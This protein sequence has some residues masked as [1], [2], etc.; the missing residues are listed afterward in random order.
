MSQ[1]TAFLVATG[2]TVLGTLLRQT[3]IPASLSNIILPAISLPTTRLMLNLRSSQMGAPSPNVMA[4]R[5]LHGNYPP[6]Q[7]RRAGF[8]MGMSGVYQGRGG[9]R[10][11]EEGRTTFVEVEMDITQSEHVHQPHT[12]VAL[13]STMGKWD[14][15]A[16]SAP[17]FASQVGLGIEETRWMDMESAPSLRT[18]DHISSLGDTRPHELRTYEQPINAPNAGTCNPSGVTP[19]VSRP[20]SDATHVSGV[21]TVVGSG[22]SEVGQEMFFLRQ[23]ARKIELIDGKSQ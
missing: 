13:W 4:Q 10:I 19:A 20:M 11:K 12:R 14:D 9:F 6:T 16:D 21:S 5:P 15:V 3:E 18:L 22:V 7:N 17:A 1:L 2:F 23:E 8:A